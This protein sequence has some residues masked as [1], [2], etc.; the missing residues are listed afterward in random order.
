MN[1][2]FPAISS[3]I[4]G[5]PTFRLAPLTVNPS[6]ADSGKGDNGSGRGRCRCRRNL[7]CEAITL[8]S[9]CIPAPPAVSSFVW[10]FLVPSGVELDGCQ[11]APQ[12]CAS[13]GWLSCSAA[14]PSWPPGGPS[15]RLCSTR[16]TTPAVAPPTPPP[17]APGPPCRSARV[18]SAPLLS[19][20]S[21]RPCRNIKIGFFCQIQ[22]WE[23]FSVGGSER[24]IVA[25]EQRC[26]GPNPPWCPAQLPVD[27]KPKWPPHFPY[28]RKDNQ[29]IVCPR[30]L[31]QC[32]DLWLFF[33]LHGL[34]SL[35][36]SKQ[37]PLVERGA[38]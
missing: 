38:Q 25:I 9:I 8:C 26:G 2:F 15:S 10:I 23:A 1:V 14:T 31:L 22:V 21:F 13:T 36:L 33:S 7:H 17:A 5:H 20:S 37:I 11:P 6:C 27:Y 29:N 35:R 24:M 30:S 28:S 32:I 16:T 4:S 34:H 19:P 3:A 18:Q 12:S